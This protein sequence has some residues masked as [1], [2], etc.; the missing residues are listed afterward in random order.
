MLPKS[1]SRGV[2][3][4]NGSGSRSLACCR[5]L[6]FAY[7]WLCGLVSP[8]LPTA[9]VQAGQVVCKLVK[10]KHSGIQI[11]SFSPANRFLRENG[12]SQR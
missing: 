8:S 5:H 10:N 12:F 6:D 7:F 1:S 11:S 3:R 9:Q 2:C 4:T